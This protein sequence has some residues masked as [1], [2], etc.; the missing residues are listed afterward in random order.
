MH[1][2]QVNVTR[3]EDQARATQACRRH[4]RARTGRKIDRRPLRETNRQRRVGARTDPTVLCAFDFGAVDGEADLAAEGG[5]ARRQDHRAERRRDECD[6]EPAGALALVV[7]AASIEERSNL[8]L[9]GGARPRGSKDPANH[10]RQQVFTGAH[11][12]PPARWPRHP[13]SIEQMQSPCRTSVVSARAWVTNCGTSLSVRFC[14]DSSV[15]LQSALFRLSLLR[16]SSILIVL[17]A[18]CSRE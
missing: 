15:G 11:D 18:A 1:D 16:K 3:F 14:F 8:R 13:S 5:D 9:E 10:S 2:V 7:R 12:R 6:R 4:P 17:R